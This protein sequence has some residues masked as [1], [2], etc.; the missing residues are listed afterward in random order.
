MINYVIIIDVFI[1]LLL[2]IINTTR[3]Q[4]KSLMRFILKCYKEPRGIDG[5]DDVMNVELD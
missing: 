3:L 1:I 5:A 2:F 4:F